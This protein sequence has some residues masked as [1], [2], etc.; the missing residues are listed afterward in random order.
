M[1]VCKIK[2]DEVVFVWHDVKNI[3]ELA[4]KYGLEGAEYV[5][6]DDGVI[7]GYLFKDGVFTAPPP[8]PPSDNPNDYA[9]NRH[10]WAYFLAVTGY[11]DDLHNILA[12][13]KKDDRQAY[14]RLMG[15][16]NREH[17]EFKKVEKHIENMNGLLTVEM[18][19]SGRGKAW[20]EAAGV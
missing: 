5:Q 18:T 15:L 13:T 12:Q 8:P 16:T 11:D 9:L 14:A 19:Q 10:Q 3:D 7:A 4:Q 17:F 20:I 1:S 6:C 2:K